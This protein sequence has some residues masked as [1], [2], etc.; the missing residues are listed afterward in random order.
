MT[1]NEYLLGTEEGTV[2]ARSVRRLADSSRR[3]NRE[4]MEKMIGVPWDMG[5]TIGRPKRKADIA[6]PQTPNLIPTEETAN[7]SP[8]LEPSGEVIQEEDEGNFPVQP[9]P[10]SAS[11]PTADVGG[12]EAAPM[13]L[14]MSAMGRRIR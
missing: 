14:G 2:T 1:S 9:G 3:Y 6:L 8:R 11:R 4:L 13:D 12:G 10:S 5:T 7:E